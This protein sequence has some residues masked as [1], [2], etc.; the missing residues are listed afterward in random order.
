MKR[1]EGEIE[2]CGVLMS[3]W[4]TERL[5]AVDAAAVSAGQAEA[6]R[7][8]AEALPALQDAQQAVKDLEKKDIAEMK[9]LPNPP[10]LVRKTME[11]ICIM[12][13]EKP[14]IRDICREGRGEGS[15]VYTVFFRR[16][17]FC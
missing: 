14:G 2:E 16:L 15:L 13:K 17:G 3:V 6:E 7:E 1:R 8:L 10:P 5:V 12:F 9:V 11:I 4:L